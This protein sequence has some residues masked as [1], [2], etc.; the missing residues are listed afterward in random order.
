MEVAMME[1]CNGIGGNYYNR[2]FGD[3]YE[4]A[5]DFVEDY[6]TSELYD[7]NNCISNPTILYYLLYSRYGNSTVAAYDE[8]R[9]RYNLYSIIFM[10]GPAWEA[11]LRI[12]KEFRDLIGSD[13]LF[14]GS[15]QINNHSFNPSAAPSTDTF[16][17]LPTINDQ[18]ANRR[19][20]PKIEAYS[21]LMAVLKNDVSA[22]FIDK[23]KHLFLTIVEPNAPLWYGTTPEEEEI[24][25]I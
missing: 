1:L 24:L 15:T 25:E 4:T 18:T 6:T 3:I 19:V 20:K 22:E 16:A 11:K 7:P 23:F 9:F 10:Y 17:A 8:N 2:T 5:A 14:T 21:G 13:E 12:Q